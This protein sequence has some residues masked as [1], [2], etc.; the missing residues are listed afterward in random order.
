M[1]VSVPTHAA[2]LL[3]ATCMLLTEAQRRKMQQSLPGI[4]YGY[5]SSQLAYLFSALFSQDRY[6]LLYSSATSK[7]LELE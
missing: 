3:L 7:A 4:A 2:L 6:E 1:L 5:R